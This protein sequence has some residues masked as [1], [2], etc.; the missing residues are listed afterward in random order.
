MW[1]YENAE[2]FLA[3]GGG[4]I[5]FA[6]IIFRIKWI[7]DRE[8]SDST[9]NFNRIE[10]APKSNEKEKYTDTEVNNIDKNAG[11]KRSAN[12]LLGIG[13]VIC[14]VPVVPVFV[15]FIG[16]GGMGVNEKSE[17]YRKKYARQCER[18]VDRIF[19]C[20]YTKIEGE[21]NKNWL[22]S[23]K[24]NKILNVT[25]YCSVSDEVTKIP[26]LPGVKFDKYTHGAVRLSS[27]CSYDIICVVETDGD[28]YDYR[29]SEVKASNMSAEN[30]RTSS[31]RDP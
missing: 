25:I 21:E 8:N 23:F 20:N 15:L 7:K 30:Y 28:S 29:I 26:E 14:A 13:I 12:A 3:F 22:W 17:I 4:L 11:L 10:R 5:L 9:S 27:K 18:E 31:C 1:A 24:K 16:S 2:G 6:L 19:S